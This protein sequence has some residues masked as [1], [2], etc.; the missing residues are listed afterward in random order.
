MLGTGLPTLPALARV[1]GPI[2]PVLSSNLC[3]AWAVTQALD[4]GAA[5]RA[6]LLP[7]LQGIGWQG[8]LR[9]RLEGQPSR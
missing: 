1:Q 6:T 8:R 5:D 9:A 3:L 2:P 4:A 7:W